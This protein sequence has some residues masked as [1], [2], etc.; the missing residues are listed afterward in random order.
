MIAVFFCEQQ[1][2]YNEPSLRVITECAFEDSKQS[3]VIDL[4]MIKYLPF[5][6]RHYVSN[7]LLPKAIQQN[8][9]GS[10]PFDIVFTNLGDLKDYNA[11]RRNL[12]L[13]ETVETEFIGHKWT[14]KCPTDLFPRGKYFS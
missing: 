9:C 1:T 6:N 3:L 7:K 8:K 12:P 5:S 10:N 4:D 11:I 13:T 14:N 2:P